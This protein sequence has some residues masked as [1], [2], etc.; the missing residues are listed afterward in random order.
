M[1]TKLSRAVKL[2]HMQKIAIQDFDPISLMQE[3]LAR[4]SMKHP[5]NLDSNLYIMDKM[6]EGVGKGLEYADEYFLK[7]RIPFLRQ[8]VDTINTWRE[9]NPDKLPQMPEDGL[10]GSRKIIKPSSISLPKPSSISLPKPSSISLPK[11]S[12][13]SLPKPSIAEPEDEIAMIRREL[14]EAKRKSTTDSGK[15]VKALKK[16]K[17]LRR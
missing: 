2:R 9:E 6:N 16:I 12:S 17:R 8:A 5:E 1:F 7:G 3:N 11:P 4:D 15:V 13:I 10:Y 14:A